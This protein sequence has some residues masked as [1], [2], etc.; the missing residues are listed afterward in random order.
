MASGDLRGGGEPVRMVLSNCN[1]RLAV[2]SLATFERGDVAASTILPSRF[3]R[4][5]SR[6]VDKGAQFGRVS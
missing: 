4:T 2:D 6:H 3:L 5:S 1:Y